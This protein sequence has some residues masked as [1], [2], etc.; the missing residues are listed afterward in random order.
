KATSEPSPPNTTNS[1]ETPERKLYKTESP[2]KHTTARNSSA[3]S[4]SLPN[5][6]VKQRTS[7]PHRTSVTDST[8]TSTTKSRPS[9]TVS[10]RTTYAQNPSIKSQHQKTN[11]HHLEP[12]HHRRYIEN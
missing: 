7:H 10:A 12:P 9:T 4:M 11:N 1:S 6:T 8:P 3:S 5:P 2:H